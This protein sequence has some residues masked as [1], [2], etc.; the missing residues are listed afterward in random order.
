MFDKNKTRHGDHFSPRVA[1]DAREQ[2]GVRFSWNRM[3]RGVGCALSITW[4]VCFHVC[5]I[6]QAFILV[7][8][9]AKCGFSGVTVATVPV[10]VI[11]LRGWPRFALGLPFLFVVV[12][13]LWGYWALPP[14]W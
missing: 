1:F 10:M 7:P 13:T 8:L 2:R 4:I 6:N 5:V 12:W 9:G 11:C 3:L 14:L